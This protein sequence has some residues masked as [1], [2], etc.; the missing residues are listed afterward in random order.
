MNCSSPNTSKG[1]SSNKALEIYNPTGGMIDMSDYAIYRFNNGSTSATDSLFPQGMLAS[2]DVFVI[3]N[4]SANATILAESDTT[5]TMTFYN[6][7]DAIIL[8]NTAT[9]DTLDAIGEIG[10]DPGSGWTV[11]AGA[12]NNFTLR[13][14][15]T[16]NAGNTN[17]SVGATE[18]DVFPI[19]DVADLGMHTSDCASTGCDEL[20]FSE[21][22][23]GSSSNKA[24]EI[25]NP[26]NAMVDLSDYAIYRFNNGS[27]SATDSLFPQGML[28]GYEVFVIGNPSGNA[29]ILAESDTLHTMTFYN[30]D[31]ALIL[32]N[33]MT[34]DT[35][36][37]IGEI[38]VDPGSSW[39]VG[40]GATQN[41]TLRRMSTVKAG[42]TDWAVGATE[43]DVFP[44]DDVADLGMH[45]SDCAIVTGCDEL[46]FSEYIEGSSSNKALEIYNPTNGMVDLSHYEVRRFNNGGTTAS[47]S[48]V[49][50]G[51]LAA[52]D[53]YVIG[54][55]GGNATI[56]AESDTTHSMT[57]YNG[58]D[59][60]I[61]INTMTGDTIDGIGEIGVDPGSG[62]P[63]GTGATNNTTLR[64]MFNISEGNTDWAVGATEWDVFA[65]DDVSDLGEHSS[66]CEPP[67][68][69]PEVSFS[70]ESLDVN[71]GDGTISFDVEITNSGADTVAVD[72]AMAMAGSAALGTDFTWAD[73]TISFPANATMPV[74]LNIGLIDDSDV[75]GDETIVLGLSNATNG[76][77][78]GD[79]ILVITIEDNDYPVYPIAL[80]T[81]DANGDG[82]ADSLG[83]RCQVQGIVH[84]IDIQGG[85][86]IEFTFIDST[87]GIHLYSN[88]DFG[89]TVT[90]GDEVIVQGEVD[91]FNAL[92]QMSPD[93][94]IVVSTGNPTVTPVSVTTLDETTE[95][96]LVVLECFSIIDTTQW[97][98]SG[99]GSV[100]L[101]VTNGTDT[102]TMRIDSDTDINGTPA[103]TA[104]WLTIT[105]LGGQFAFGN[106]DTADFGY[107]ILPNFITDIVENP[108]PTVGFASD[109][110]SEFESA[111]SVMVMVAQADGNPDTTMLEMKLDS[112]GTT[113]TVGVDF[114]WD[115]FTLDITGCGTDTFSV[116][117]TL[118]DDLDVEGDEFVSIFIASVTNN[119]TVSIDTLVITIVDDATD[120]IDDLLPA[121]AIKLYPNPVS[122][123]LFLEADYRLEAIRIYNL[124]GQELI[125]QD[126]NAQQAELTV[127]H[128]PNGVYLIKVETSEGIWTSRFIR[129]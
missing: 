128:L 56:L 19:D 124:M 114:L 24:L 48:L 55:A 83:V 107:Q 111:G 88:N 32:I 94:I 4:P 116:P 102:L 110:I 97:P 81:E 129:K 20:F 72:I 53:V 37:A 123:R 29:T 95:N 101:D 11:G 113:A 22:I 21:Y 74:T 86:A 31:D 69:T 73:T 28:S 79:T 121:H 26:T 100:N 42:N 51:M 67:S 44:I 76:A 13:R 103:P 38:G 125:R 70:T 47:D 18:W 61:L 46:F 54:N 9:G 82:H 64:R 77:A 75:E 98:S 2:L 60:I 40:S 43:W 87:G 90:E 15:S 80:V 108:D 112:V 35:L 16:V 93:T 10:V 14:M 1:S 105:G 71:E 59:A 92:V 41:Y 62:W 36:D 34:G 6:G 63:V 68:N 120:A 7:D 39:T 109:S 126:L 122:S 78:I 115:D 50:D 57:F 23:E 106:P 58:D 118:I 104:K 3:G 85:N 84:G 65:N 99:G 117:V 52:Y 49:L 33:T 17:W 45:T 8:I 30:G 119:A 127:G 12:T 66:A 89:Y 5:H 25:Y 96:E 91:E 27:T